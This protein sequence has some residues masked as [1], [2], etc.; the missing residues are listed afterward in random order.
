MNNCNF[1]FQLRL[2]ILP[3]QHPLTKKNANASYFPLLGAFSHP[4]LSLPSTHY[5]K[6]RFSSITPV[7]LLTSR[8]SK[9]LVPPLLPFHNH[10]YS[11]N[12]KTNHNYYNQRK[13]FFS[14]GVNQ[15]AED[16]NSASATIEVLT[17]AAS[18]HTR[19]IH[20]I[21]LAVLCGLLVIVLGPLGKISSLHSSF[22]I[23]TKKN[24]NS[25]Y[26]LI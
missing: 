8:S 23:I 17:E 13:R 1:S 14:S 2:S 12:Y 15:I 22:F 5:A 11:Y 25:L 9:V 3:F 18:N 7:K 21:L 24:D 16:P 10:N 26:F 4:L 6:S 20:W 19:A